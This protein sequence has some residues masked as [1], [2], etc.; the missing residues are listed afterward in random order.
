MKLS[1]IIVNYNVRYFL[2]QALLSVRKAMEHLTDQGWE[3][4]VFVVDNNSV[5]DSV[6]MVKERFPE[7]KLIANSGNPGFS[8]ANNQAIRQSTGEYALLLNPDTIVNE[9]TFS[10]CVEFMDAHPEAG[11]LGVRMIDGSGKFLPESKRGFPSPFVAFCKTFGLSKL[12][13][14][15]PRFNRYHLGH[16]P[17]NKTHEVD[18]LAGAF[19]WLRRSTLDQ[20]G[21]LDEAFFMYGEDI[22]LSYRIVQGGYQNF[23]YPETTIIHYK[24][25]STKKGS[26]NYVRVFYQAMIIFAKKHF[27][28]TKGRLFILMLQMAIYLRAGMTLVA[29]WGKRLA[30]PLLDAALIA[31]GLILLK[32]FWANYYYGNPHYFD[33]RFLWF[34][35]PLYTSVWLFSVFLNGGYDDTNSLRRPVRGLLFG[36]VLLAAIYGFLDLEFRSSR[37][38]IVLGA[39][40]AF[41]TVILSRLSLHFI[42]YKNFNIGKKINNNLVVIGSEEEVERTMRLLQKAQANKNLIGTVT[43]GKADGTGQALGRFSQLDEIVRLYKVHEIIFCSRDVSS[44]GIMDAMTRLGSA[45]QYKILPEES[46][47]IIGSHSKNRSGEL[48]TIDI[49][50]R[51]ADTIQ[52]RNKRLLDIILSF[53]F[54]VGS[55]L[56]VLFMEN[57]GGFL[58]NIFLVLFN[59]KTWVGYANV[60]PQRRPLPRLAPSVL[61]PA[62]AFD[63]NLQDPKTLQRLNFLYAKDYSV[64]EDLNIIWA[65]WRKLG[66]Q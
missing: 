2:E 15:S 50:Y 5:D 21:L 47:S 6:Q 26:L 12:F 34:N 53:C 39:F 24:G 44:Q 59:K 38:L 48:Y 51:I 49:Q 64:Q 4:E 43:P 31:G 37:M 58:K 61:H 3:S 17:E 11:G 28:G 10:K 66:G 36:T 7:V 29:N 9:D 40:W 63:I 22:D 55:P 33:N 56:L 35:I 30:L 65:G 20:V 52:R 41:A 18:V 25:E 32:D 54:L 60:N 16:L 62:D 27:T 19:M 45:L 1:I 8:I 13:P 23:Y 14:K 42:Q 57:K 46:L